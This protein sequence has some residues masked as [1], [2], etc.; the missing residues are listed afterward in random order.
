M[1]SQLASVE[2]KEVPAGNVAKPSARRAKAANSGT[3]DG[4]HGGHYP[5]IVIGAG[6]A[7]LSVGYHLKRR[8]VPFV[9]LDANDRIGDQW[10]RRWDSLRL[11]TP[12]RFDGLDGMAFPA[13]RFSFPTKDDMGD[14]LE[15]YAHRFDLPVRTGVR[16]DGLRPGKAGYV[17][18]SG[19]VEWSADQVVVAMS[20]FQRPKVPSFAADLDPAIVQLH[21]SDYRSP[22][23]MEE[24]D[25]L[26]VGGGNSGSEI[27]REL[28]MAGHRVHMA[29]RHPGHIPFRV[30]GFLGRHL[31][32]PLVLRVVFYRLLTT[33]TPMGRRARKKVLANGEQLVRVKPKDLKRLGVERVPRVTGT[34]DGLPQLQDGRVLD[35]ANV[36]WCSGFHPG[37]DW[38]DLP[39]PEGELV[40]A[41]D[42]GVVRSHPG[43]YFTGLRFLYAMSSIM[44]QGAGRDARHIAKKVAARASRQRVASA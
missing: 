32:V 1:I 28:S 27:A 2:A 20:D 39:I 26:V 22:A 3:R 21:S 24:G 17:V 9:I 35:V 5:V 37:F 11:F 33:S 7:G 43:L 6:Q 13:P 15:A 29:G 30:E 41:H 18:T 38:I 23:Q 25:V 4:E 16:V 36:I 8:G 31:F 40:P 10:R 14:F 34:R 19:K 42:R 12:A 44:I